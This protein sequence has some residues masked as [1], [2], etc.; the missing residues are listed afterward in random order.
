LNDEL[1][2]RIRFLK[3]NNINRLELPLYR[4]RRHENNITNNL[5][6]LEKHMDDLV[7][8]HGEGARL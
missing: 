7:E 6:A 8:K 4:Y 5:E 3:K 2:L 1:D